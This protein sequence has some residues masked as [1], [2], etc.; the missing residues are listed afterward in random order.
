[1][2]C[3]R[4]P[5]ETQ[6]GIQVGAPPFPRNN[7]IISI[8][9]C[10]MQLAQPEIMHFAPLVPHFFLVCHCMAIQFMIS[11]WGMKKRSQVADT[12]IDFEGCAFATGF[13]HN[14]QTPSISVTGKFPKGIHPFHLPTKT[15][16]TGWEL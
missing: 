3:I 6:E 16:L 7:S 12:T 10:G 4:E 5:L 15:I 9:N 2:D 1:M 13:H 11:P 8:S 14:Y